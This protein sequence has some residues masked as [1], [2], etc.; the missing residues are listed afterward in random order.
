MSLD[1]SLNPSRRVGWV[2]AAA[3]AGALVCVLIS[4]AP[5]AVKL[6]LPFAL[7]ASLIYGIRRYALLK[8]NRSPRRLVIGE[9]RLRA[10][11]GANEEGNEIVL[12]PGTVNSRRWVIL[13]AAPGRIRRV[14]LL[15][16]SDM[17]GA[18]QWRRLRVWMTVQSGVDDKT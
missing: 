4:A 11:L 2:L 15:L 10:F 7:I 18:D 13:H 8:D 14:A 6:I 9:D 16:A 3:H 5:P 1:I 17:M 12:S